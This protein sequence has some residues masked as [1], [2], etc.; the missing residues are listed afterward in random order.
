[1][2]TIIKKESLR[3]LCCIMGMFLLFGCKQSLF[4]E[5]KNYTESELYRPN[6]HFTPKKGWM[7]DPNGMFYYNGYYHLF[8]QYYPDSNVWGPMHWGIYFLGVVYLI[9]KMFV[10]YLVKIF[11]NKKELFYFI[12]I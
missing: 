4:N 11:A 3:F 2:K 10:N 5:K 12:Q 1:M 8:Y 6:F 9:K 7:N